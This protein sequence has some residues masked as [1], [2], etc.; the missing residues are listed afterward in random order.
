MKTIPIIF[1]SI[2]F[3][4]GV[5]AEKKNSLA[6]P[7]P[8]FVFPAGFEVVD[9]EKAKEVL[10]SDELPMITTLSK[11]GD[12]VI[13]YDSEFHPD[14]DLKLE[15][16]KS[17][18]PGILKQQSPDLK[19]VAYDYIEFDG[20]LWIYGEFNSTNPEDKRYNIIMQTVKNDMLF[21]V[22]VASTREEF[23]KIGTE[24]RN[25][26]AKTTLRVAEINLTPTMEMSEVTSVD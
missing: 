5:F 24:I 23:A 26:L 13:T 14:K 7:K 16:L 10:G 21:N 11:S 8:H 2:V 25:C 20:D 1:A 9:S 12:T 15:K 18:L 3:V 22:N 4:T 6:L 17:V 19:F